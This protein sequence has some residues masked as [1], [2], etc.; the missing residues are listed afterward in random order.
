MLLLRRVFLFAFLSVTFYCTAQPDLTINDL[1][2]KTAVAEAM[3]Q[4][5]IWKEAML[6]NDTAKLN[7]ILT[8]DFKLNGRVEK[9]EWL[10]NLTHY[11]TDSITVLDPEFTIYTNAVKVDCLIYWKYSEGNFAEEARMLTTDIWILKEGKLLL[12]TRLWNKL[13]N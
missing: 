7:M 6:S 5:G 11:K 10:S 1:S 12:Q 9:Y 2:K 13:R 4:Y 3:K 8:P